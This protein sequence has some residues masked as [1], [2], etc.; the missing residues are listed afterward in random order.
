MKNSYFGFR[1]ECDICPKAFMQYRESD[2]NIETA[3]W[4]R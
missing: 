1:T 3:S 4:S 2:L